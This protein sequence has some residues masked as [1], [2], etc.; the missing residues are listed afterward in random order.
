M[1][2]TAAKSVTITVSDTTRVSGL[3][4]KPPHARACYVLAHGAGA[5][6]D[7]PF[8][9]NVAR[10][11]ASR[12]IAT[13][14]YQFPYMER[15][16]KRPD[17]PPLAQ[18]TVRA[19][20]AEAQRLLP[21]T[22]LIAGGKSFGGRMTSQAQAKAPLEGVHGLAFLGFPLHPA[23]RPSQDRAEHLFEIQIPM[24]FLQGTRDNLA[25]LDQLKPACKQLGKRATLKLFADADH[26]FHVPARTGRKDAQV[27]DDVLDALAA[28]LDS[29]ILRPGTKS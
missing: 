20:V 18:A 5:G 3:M 28:W 27:L 11:L 22:A 17:P 2:S 13:L 25:S 19:A 21:D 1:T 9:D 8:M 6:M 26:S 7:H 23:G 16:S 29:V 14:R 15:G 12:G 4:Q 24:L 10:G